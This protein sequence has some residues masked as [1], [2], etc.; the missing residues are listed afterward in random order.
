M[1]SHT[2]LVHDLLLIVVMY[3][4]IA[5]YLFN[6]LHCYYCLE[7]VSSLTGATAVTL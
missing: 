1:D 3:M 5:V 6:Y 7:L 2:L 4:A